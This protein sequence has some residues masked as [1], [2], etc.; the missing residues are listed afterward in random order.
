M[1][2]F[3]AGGLP[4]ELGQGPVNLP[5]AMSIPGH[6]VRRSGRAATAWSHERFGPRPLHPTTGTVTMRR[7]TPDPSTITRHPATHRSRLA[8]GFLWAVQ[9]LLAALFLFGGGMKLVMPVAALTADTP[10]PGT[11]LRAVGMVEVLGALGLVLPGLL[12][13]HPALTPLAAGGLV[14]MMCG[15][16]GATM[17]SP[18]Y[19]AQPTMALIPAAVGALAALVA[20]ARAASLARPSPAGGARG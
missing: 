10:L 19:S 9:A 16:V 14:L 15:A 1:E 18:A 20:V 13:L 3:A 5:A 6:V 2:D 4:V 7:P 8:R 12:R 11:F 17:A